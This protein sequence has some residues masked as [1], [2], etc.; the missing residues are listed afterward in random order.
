MA[1]ATPAPASQR[2]DH[3]L[4]CA[5]I[6]KT[7]TACA[8]LVTLG[9]I[10]INRQ[11]T[12]KPDF[13]IRIGDVLTVFLG[14]DVRVLRVRALAPRRGSARDAALLFAVIPESAPCPPARPQAAPPLSCASAESAAYPPR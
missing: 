14:A 11:A 7:R 12:A 13:R 10:R 4:W 1:E 6:R 8:E 9:R 5:R 3:W 2:L